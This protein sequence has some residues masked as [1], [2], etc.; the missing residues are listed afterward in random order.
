M[1]E[2]LTPKQKAFADYYIETGN[3]T[4]AAIKAGYSKKTAAVIGAENLIKPNIKSYIEKRLREIENERIMNATE[5]MEL[6]TA[7]ARG[8]LEEEIIVTFKEGYARVRKQ[9]DIHQR[10]K[11]LEQIL[12]RYPL[13][14][15][16]ELK[17]ELLKAQ[18]EK[19]KAETKELEQGEGDVT[20]VV[21][22]NDI[23]EMRKVLHERSQNDS[24][25]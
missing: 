4:E 21:I 9:P 18:I 23:D 7:I 25:N 13:G 22:V 19:I 6:L 24:N 11:A 1:S 2:K 10:L 8:E 3:A 17:E 12:K 16:D 15:Q 20:R 14:K 5:A